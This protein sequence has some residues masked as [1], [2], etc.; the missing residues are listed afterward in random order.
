MYFGKDKEAA[1][2][3]FIE[4]CDKGLSPFFKFFNLKGNGNACMTLARLYNAE[5]I[6]KIRNKDNE[7]KHDG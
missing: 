7:H 6:K 4:T 2:K 3:L 5:H 1:Q